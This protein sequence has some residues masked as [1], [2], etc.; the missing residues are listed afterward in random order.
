MVRVGKVLNKR[1]DPHPKFKYMVTFGWRYSVH[2]YVHGN[3]MVNAS[4]LMSFNIKERDQECFAKFMV[5]LE[6]NISSPV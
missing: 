5:I 4:T 2:F 3:F 1:E 6:I